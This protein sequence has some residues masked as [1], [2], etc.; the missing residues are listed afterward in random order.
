MS[1]AIAVARARVAL[2]AAASAG[3]ASI[4][5]R[6]FEVRA[7]RARGGRSVL[8]YRGPDGE[9]LVVKRYP[10]ADEAATSFA[11][12]A[13]LWDGGFG[14]GAMNRVP[15]PLGLFPE[16]RAVV[17]AGAAGRRPTPVRGRIDEWIDGAGRAATW[18]AALHRSA[19]RPP[20][21]VTRD[22]IEVR[23][24][25]RAARAIHSR[26]HLAVPLERRLAALAERRVAAG[27]GAPLAPTHGRYHAGHVFISPDSV[28]VIDL[29]RLALGDPA[30]DLGE[31]LH[32]LRLQAARR[33]VIG[34]ADLATGEFL[35][36]YA[37]HAGAMPAGV[38]YHWAASALGTACRLIEKGTPGDDRL[39]GHW[40]AA[41]D[42][43]PEHLDERGTLDVRTRPD[44]ETRP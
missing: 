30:V 34:A 33:G 10:T 38:A 31:Y 2:V 24:A 20:R 40:L 21:T 28:T 25:S 29:D 5:T 32:R 43:V 11:A 36:A 41:F 18:L 7:R 15:E 22:Q 6:A 27:G 42:A 4:D 44:R 3:A 1:Q 26:P 8:A 14:S 35:A 9:R 23:V 19:A 16:W 17:M 13:L 39:V 12:L 37:G